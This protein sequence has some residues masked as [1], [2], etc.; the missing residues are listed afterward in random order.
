MLVNITTPTSA[1]T[2][3]NSY[4]IIC[5]AARNPPM[6]EYL[7]LEPQPAMMMPITSS[8]LIATRNTTPV[9]SAVPG[10]PINGENGSTANEAITGAI[11]ADGASRNIDLSVLAAC[12]SSLKNILPTSAINCKLPCGPV[13]KGPTRSCIQAMS[14]RSR[15]LLMAAPVMGNKK[16]KNTAKINYTNCP[17]KIKASNWPP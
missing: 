10:R 6:S 2:S 15:K 7:L 1:R 9:A 4:E 14:F 12:T 8:E 17:Q 5:A 11:K 13:C 3:G 16:A